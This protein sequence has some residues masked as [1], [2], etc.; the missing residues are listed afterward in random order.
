MSDEKKGEK[1]VKGA[2]FARHRT[3][4]GQYWFSADGPLPDPWRK[5]KGVPA[6][7]DAAIRWSVFPNELGT[8]VDFIL[9]MLDSAS[10]ALRASVERQCGKQAEGLS[11]AVIDLEAIR[12]R[13][14]PL[15]PA[16]PDYV[17]RL[18]NWVLHSRD[19]VEALLAEV[20]RLRALVQEVLAAL[21]D[22]DK[23]EKLAN[24]H[25]REYTVVPE[26]LRTWARRAREA[27]AMC[28]GV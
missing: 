7:A 28:G 18:L 15:D 4:D 5:E 20:V 14:E 2:V 26:T 21:P 9:H 16:D 6:A 22:P 11:V 27:R 25:D 1:T 3:E 10:A 23:L 24:A 17:A 19:D 12:K 13:H 8:N